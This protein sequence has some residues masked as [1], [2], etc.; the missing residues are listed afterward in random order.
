MNR[1][2]SP[3][4]MSDASTVIAPLTIAFISRQ[5]VVWLGLQKIFEGREASRIVV[6]LY[7]QLTPCALLPENQPDLFLLDLGTERDPIGTI[8]KIRE[9]A[10]KSKIVVLSGLEEMDLTRKTLE[11]GVDGVILNVQPPA[12]VL[13]AI[14]A[15]YHPPNYP[16]A[17]ERN[18]AVYVELSKAVKKRADFEPQPP[19]WTDVLTEREQEVARMVGQGH[20]N[21]EIAYRLSI[22]DSTVRHH[23]TNIFGKIGVPNRQKL[24]LQTQHFRF[25]SVQPDS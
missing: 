11:Y 15:L 12:V 20:S 21:K 8:R 10:P 24:L 16:A 4:F 6:Q 2:L 5:Y 9:S 13:A 18:E 23:L 3:G 1:D 25:P 22:S 7:Q 17:A 14:E 19:V